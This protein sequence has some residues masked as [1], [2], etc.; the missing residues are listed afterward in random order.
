MHYQV[1]EL[2]LYSGQET[3]PFMN[4]IKAAA[5]RKSKDDIFSRRGRRFR[6]KY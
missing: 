4:E 2:K 6:R 3:R 1:K 5:G